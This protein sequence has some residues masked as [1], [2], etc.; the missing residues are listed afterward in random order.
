MALQQQQQA[1]PGEQ[2]EVK[3]QQAYPPPPPFYRLYRP[4][5]DG[6][7]ERPLPPEP[8]KP[9]EGEYVLFGEFHSTESGVPPLTGRPLFEPRPNGTIDFK[10][11]LLKLN[12]ELLFNFLELL[13]TLVDRPS[14]YAR[15]VEN[16]G[17]IMRN[18]HYLLNIMRSHQARA[19]LQEILETEIEERKAAAQEI[20]DQIESAQKV[21]QGLAEALADVPSESAPTASTAA[22]MDTT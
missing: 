20:R 15:Q 5:A 17:L 2:Q 14:A 1:P 16:L 18:M 9:V 19:T 13:D 10:G 11:H 3:Q 12:K 7:A 6:S 22:D 4:D 21:M 8:P